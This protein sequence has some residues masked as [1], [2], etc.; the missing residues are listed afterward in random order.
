MTTTTP[1]TQ[2]IEAFRSTRQ[3]PEV[4]RSLSLNWNDE[5]MDAAQLHVNRHLPWCADSIAGRSELP[6]DAWRDIFGAILVETGDSFALGGAIRGKATRLR[7][8]L[9]TANGR[10]FLTADGKVDPIM[11]VQALVLAI[12]ERDSKDHQGGDHC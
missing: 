8:C 12:L 5:I 7:N 11:W 4:L 1:K 9:Y 6:A 2:F 3:D 10:P